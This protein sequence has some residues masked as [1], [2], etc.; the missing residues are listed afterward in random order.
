MSDADDSWIF[1][2]EVPGW[3]SEDI[4][5]DYLKEKAV[6]GQAPVIDQLSPLVL[7]YAGWHVRRAGLPQHGAG[8]Y[9]RLLG[10]LGGAGDSD[11]YQA[12]AEAETESPLRP[13]PTEGPKDTGPRKFK[14]ET[15]DVLKDALTPVE[16]QVEAAEFL[17]SLAALARGDL[18]DY[19]EDFERFVA[20]RRKDWEAKRESS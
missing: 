12:K 16:E 3:Q 4:W 5:R 11:W 19:Q 1:A 15:G 9:K 8:E 10:S 7:W 14:K 18:G 13:V 6:S 20:S 17:A 2:T